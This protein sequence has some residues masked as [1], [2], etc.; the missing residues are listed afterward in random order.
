MT[1]EGLDCNEIV[2]LVTDYLEGA[3]DMHTVAAFE[4]HLRGC[5]GCRRFVE[6]IRQTIAAIGAVSEPRLSAQA[7]ENL[8]TAFRTFR[9]PG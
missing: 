8:H 3:L 7:E 4:D 6:Q 5:E 9:R 2:E 1:A